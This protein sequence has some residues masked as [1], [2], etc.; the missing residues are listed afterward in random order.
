MQALVLTVT[1]PDQCDTIKLTTINE[2]YRNS[3]VILFSINN[4]DEPTHL[5]TVPL[6]NC[7]DILQKH[8]NNAVT[9]PC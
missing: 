3:S 4:N 8:D 5:M 1:G 7:L 2:I 9:V 6:E